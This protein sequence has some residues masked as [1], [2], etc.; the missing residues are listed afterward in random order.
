MIIKFLLYTV[1]RSLP[2]G[3]T[4]PSNWIGYSTFTSDRT[5]YIQLASTNLFNVYLGF[6]NGV[7]PSGALTTGYTTNYS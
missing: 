7:Y 2:T 4:A 6:N 5:P 1:P 3:Y